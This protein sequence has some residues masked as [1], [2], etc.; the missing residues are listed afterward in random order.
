MKKLT[1]RQR[2][3]I[4]TKLKIIEV[5]ISLSRDSNFEDLT[6]NEICRAADISVG[7]FY[8][9]FNSK[10]DII[11]TGYKQ[12]DLLL[13]E[14]FDA[15]VYPDF[16]SKITA[17]FCE[18]GALLEKLGVNFVSETYRNQLITRAE[19]SFSM[20]RPVYIEAKRL[21]VE[22]M[23]DHKLN[24][25]ETTDQITQ[26]MMRIVRGSI[27]DW[28]LNNGRTK[29]TLSIEDDLSIYLDLLWK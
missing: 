18:G 8:H 10:K 23:K 5:A 15:E 19:Y 7:A 27:F 14:K 28:C 9:H 26:R 13:E 24:T 12:I 17:L 4:E 20:E 29:L 11:T 21:V 16:R 2:Q 25:N 1:S 6:V 3:A 22:A